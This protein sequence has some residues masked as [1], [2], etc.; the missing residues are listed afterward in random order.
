MDHH[1]KFLKWFIYIYLAFPIALLLLNYFVDP[2]YRYHMNISDDQLR[3]LSRDPGKRLVVPK[4]YNDRELL[5]RYVQISGAPEICV[6]G[7]SRV[8]NL[9][10]ADNP[11]E[12]FNAGLTN[13]T[14]MDFVAVWQVFK[15]ANAVPQQNSRK[16]N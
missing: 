4:N 2:N 13:A 14:V 5:K 11:S 16:N 8:M 12:F 3:I 9:A 1:K 15:N 7:G 10:L 6:I